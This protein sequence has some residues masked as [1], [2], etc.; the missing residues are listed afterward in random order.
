VEKKYPMMCQI[1]TLC[2]T[3]PLLIVAAG[4]AFAQ[5][6]A[7]REI[8]FPLRWRPIGTT[9]VSH[10]RAG[11]SS[12]AIAGVW[13]RP[14]GKGLEV[15]LPGGRLFESSDF[16]TWS[17]RKAPGPRATLPEAAI[18][19]RLPEADARPLRVNGR[20]YRAFALGS[21]LWRSDD[22]GKNWTNLV[23]TSEIAL[24]G[25]SVRHLA[26][27]PTDPDHLAAGTS[28]GLWLSV[29]G[30]E[31]WNSL[32]QGLPNLRLTRLLS[33]PKDGRGLLAQWESGTSVEWLPGSRDAWHA[34]STP[35]TNSSR[36]WQNP[37]RPE[38]L[39]E[40]RTTENAEVWRSLDG[41]LRW[42]N[43]T[44]NLSAKR[45]YGITADATSGAIYAAT[46]KG[47]Y[48]TLNS[49]EN[50]APATN[51]V[52]LGGN[53]PR[54]AALDVLLDEGG[55][56]LYT[57]LDGD[58]VY[59]SYAPHRRGKPTLVSAA[60]LLSHPAAPG[61]LLSLQ[62]AKVDSARMDGKQIPVLSSEDGESQ[63]QI[64]YD[65]TVS[66][67]KL[68]L[69]SSGRDDIRLD[70]D[71]VDTAPVIFTDRDGAPLLLNAENG[72][73]LDPTQALRP[74][75]RLQ[76][77]LSGLGQ[78]SPAWP[79]GTPAPLQNAPR[80]VAPIRVWFEGQTLEVS[81]AELAGGYIGFYLVETKLPALVDR[82]SAVLS[83]EAAGRQSNR[84]RLW[85]E[86]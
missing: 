44:G 75:Q 67:P 12:G 82:G 14:D 40:P 36:R 31:T 41:G 58:G 74:G 60:D 32:N 51:W 24:I 19:D 34:L 18:V 56:F 25:K 11:F 37:Q 23:S 9:L 6:A 66:R 35:S 84:I 28:E 80:V 81:R 30:G 86:P 78:V 72:E 39:L 71:I 1:D 64:P 76:I 68:A 63:I 8:E 45:L 3:L 73:L 26:I 4:T 5:E 33:A 54:S 16:E 7:T 52:R 29:D 65:A 2:R 46:D 50:A 59:L 15:A 62:G 55:N 83:V 61:A 22:S 70:L 38:V 43:L 49:L 53:L 27:S 10:D 20:A 69:S 42:D 77:L 85:M 79:A 17:P 57:S 47:V 48:F 13:F 21:T